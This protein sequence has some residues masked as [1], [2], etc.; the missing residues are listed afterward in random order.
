MSARTASIRLPDMD[1]GSAC[2]AEGAGRGPQTRW[3][4]WTGQLTF[5]L[6]CTS[7]HLAKCSRQSSALIPHLQVITA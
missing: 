4:G 3:A 7:S 5:L 2:W 6:S 1:F